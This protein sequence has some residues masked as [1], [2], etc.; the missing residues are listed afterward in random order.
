VSSRFY[1]VADRR[2]R[3][4]VRERLRL[5]IGAPRENAPAERVVRANGSEPRPFTPHPA[6]LKRLLALNLCFAVVMGLV[7]LGCLFHPSILNV[8]LAMICFALASAATVA[9]RKI[10][11]ANAEHGDGND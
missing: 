8:A 3:K 9:I 11:A 4:T 5:A 7:G 10:R 2:L 6:L 1:G